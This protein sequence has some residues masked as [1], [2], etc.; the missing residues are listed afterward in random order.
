M[1]ADILVTARNDLLVNH[2]AAAKLL[3]MVELNVVDV[4]LQVVAQE[5][6]D[7]PEDLA[8]QWITENQNRV[9]AW[10]AVARASA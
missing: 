5:A 8:A 4:S 10:L 9:D 3:E 2:P 7:T 6:G 1:A